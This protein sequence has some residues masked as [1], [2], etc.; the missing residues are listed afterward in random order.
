MILKGNRRGG[1]KD[2]ALHLMKEEN[3]HVT[4]HEL[5]GFASLNL[6]DALNETYALS[7]GTRCTK[8]MY[9]MS[10]NPPP[11][12]TASTDD[13]L[14]AIEKS[15]KA[16]KLG[17]QPRAIVFHEKN[18]RRHAHVV[19][20]LINSREMKAVRLRNDRTK[21]QPL[22]RSLFIKH[23]WDMPPGLLDNKNRDPRNFTLKEY[24]Q[25]QKHG[26]DPK[27]IKSAIQSAW[28]ISD[29]RAAFV[30][31][32]EEKGMK[33]AKGDR[34]GF[35]CIDMF[36][37]YHGLRQA[38]GLR[39]KNI[40]SK[41]GNERENPELF[42]SVEQ[43]KAGMAAAM[44][45]TLN[46]LK[47]RVEHGGKQKST[48]FEHRKTRLVDAQRRERKALDAFLKK[49]RKEE[50]LLRQSR[51]RSGLKGLWDGLR[52]HNRRIRQQN[53]AEAQAARQRDREECD[54]LIFRHLKQR[55]DINLFK[56]KLREEFAKD[57]NELDR[58]MEH[59][60]H[61]RRQYSRDGPGF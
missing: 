40:R 51:F 32:L 20:S 26:R 17:G 61:I 1:A 11:G 49:R 35:V 53:E 18:G 3:D 59:Y 6:M 43:A 36:G 41:I 30:A 48:E 60:N 9:S 23:G 31:A 50:T 44:L 4:L 14:Y 57:T 47:R 29:S 7:R 8:F 25:A 58:D 45:G 46:R 16:L 52:G 27:E 34:A 28:A 42:Q 38:L 10:V 22:T 15:E 24:H 5:R 37:E 21:L 13:I 54:A 56:L 39:V 19:W 2:L 12:E 55:R 33:L